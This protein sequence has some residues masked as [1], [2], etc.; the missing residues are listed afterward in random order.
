M[1]AD[2]HYSQPQLFQLLAENVKD[3]AIF[4]IT[5][6][7][8]VQTWTMGA[9]RLLGYTADE[10]IG[11]SAD[12]LFTPE[13]L[14]N[15]E[16]VREVEGALT[17]GRG[18][19]DRWHVRKDG[20][21]F[22]SSGVLTPLRS[23][24]HALLGFAKIMRDQSNWK[25]AD[26]A[27]REGE[28]RLLALADNLPQGAI[29]RATFNPE[30]R[31]R[32]IEF[33]SAGSAQLLGLTPEEA[34]AQGDVFDQL[35]H[36]DDLH[37]VQHAEQAV[38]AG[39]HHFDLEFRIRHRSGAVRW[40]HC[41]AAPHRWVGG[42][43]VWDGVMLDVTDRKSA[44][45]ALREQE[46]WLKLALEAGKMGTWK[47]E[48]NTGQFHWSEEM[49]RLHGQVPADSAGICELDQQN[50]HPAD[51]TRVASAL[52]NAVTTGTYKIEYRVVWPEGGTHWIEARGRVFRDTEE[53]PRHLIGVGHDVTDRKRVEAD[54]RFLA[55]A[56]EALS[57]LTDYQDTLDRVAALAVPHFADWCAV[58]VANDAG[59]LDL[60]ALAHIDSGRLKHARELQARWP[61]RQESPRGISHVYRTGDTILVSEVTDEHLRECAPEEE[62]FQQLKK[63][64]IRSYM[65]V[66]L[67]VR[68]MVRGVL[69]FA[70]AQSGRNYSTADLNLAEDLGRRS[71]IA[72]ENARLYSASRAEAQRKDEFLAMLAHEL[73]NPLVPI[74]S[75]LDLLQLSDIEHEIV[76][77][78]QEQTDHLVRLVDD[79]LDVSRIM[80]GKVELRREMVDLA[81]VVRRAAD[82]I[83]PQI[84]QLSQSLSISLP[85]APAWIDADPVRM[86]QVV[87][88]LLNNAS[89]YTP[90]N[91]TIWI[92]LE[93]LDRSILLCVKD[94]GIGIPPELIPHLFDLFMQD[95]RSIDRS[96]GGLGIGLTVVKNLVEL[97]GGRVQ[98]R[99]AGIG[100]GSE[101]TVHLPRGAAPANFE[102]AA[103]AVQ[104]T[105]QLNIL[106][107][108]DNVSAAVLLARLLGKLGNHQVELAYDGMRAL[109]VL[110]GQTPDLI[111]LDIGLPLLD[112]YEVVRRLRRIPQFERV[113]VVALTGYGSEA[114]RRQAL[115]A[116]FD[117]HLVKPPSVAALRRLLESM[118]GDHPKAV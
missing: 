87:G 50:I 5:Q 70:A 105:T 31:S 106:I 54:L 27:R 111:L 58:F 77:M 73:R 74:R 47:W 20:T 33:L 102:P 3:Y 95:E 112:G 83:R 48:L 90:P 41:R 99:S 6:D 9:E 12:I 19:D 42:E 104:P 37:R 4:V 39:Q 65:C 78:M 62:Y 113:R 29:Y 64:G 60:Q 96:Q 98:A 34:R 89:K 115:E 38:L 44:E 101:F 14:L 109:E 94:S 15:N 46:D 72:S 117:E 61:Q 17:T 24:D 80:R 16:P 25:R 18:E 68:E 45:A 103:P 2:G 93:A 55:E 43:L 108:D 76:E 63:L 75:G 21:R 49:Q 53:R 30:S 40:V 35:V 116:G 82:V 81:A 97:H 79:L 118:T 26:E 66:P 51:R 85:A 1:T 69:V 59:N 22:W 23:E 71:A 7:R 28:A 52:Q 67:T 88:N 8:R 84:L 91:G 114:D 13:D 107:V 11:H 92:S 32:R 56:S 10:I 86:A 110:Q 36:V 100:Q 57:Q